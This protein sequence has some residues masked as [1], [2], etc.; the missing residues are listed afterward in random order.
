MMVVFVSHM[1]FAQTT[2]NKH[3]GIL[4]NSA[5]E[6]T[7]FDDVQVARLKNLGYTVTV[8]QQDDIG[9]TFTLDNANA[10]DL[11]IISESIQSGSADPL[12]GTTTPLMIQEPNAWDNWFHT[13]ASVVTDWQRSGEAEIVN[14]VHPIAVAAGLSVGPMTFYTTNAWVIS[15][16]AS[17]LA[18]G[19]ELI[20]QMIPL[21]ESENYT[22]AFAIDEGAELANGT[23]APNRIVALTLTGNHDVTADTMTDAAWSLYDAAI[24][25]LD[26]NT[27]GE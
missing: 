22:I 4:V 16:V 13:G 8:V 11:L 17:N 10:L 24:A 15:D 25:W 21:G 19:A 2:G 5:N 23:P 9:S 7:G 14:D 6:K 27:A 20:V 26:G 3:V 12:I 1:A 18:P